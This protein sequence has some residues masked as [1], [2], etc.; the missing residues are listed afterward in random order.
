MK[1]T[2]K[3]QKEALLNEV[4]ESQKSIKNSFKSTLSIG[5]I[6][7]K[8]VLLVLG[9]AVAAY[10]LVNLYFKSKKK[11]DTEK[12]EIAIFEKKT[13][14]ESFS[15]IG[16]I[17]KEALSLLMSFVKEVMNEAVHRIINKREKQRKKG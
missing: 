6:Q 12:K 17:K 5:G 14:A 9:S 11:T 10:G 13:H 15:L 4:K 7:G 2:Y 1:N 16:M 8:K 3:E